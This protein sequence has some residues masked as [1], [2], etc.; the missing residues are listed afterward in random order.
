MGSSVA[1]GSFGWIVPFRRGDQEFA[2]IGV[3]GKTSSI[4]YLGKLIHDLYNV[5]CL[6]C[7]NVPLR[8]WIIPVAPLPRT[9]ADRVLA[10]G[11]A[12]GQTKPITGGGIFYGLLCAEAAARTVM[13]AFKRGDFSLGT[14][15]R[16]EEEWR[17][18]LGREIRIAAFFRRLAERLTDKDIDH[19]FRIVQS[20]G[21]L[22]WVTTKAH[23]DWHGEVIYF[24]LCHPYLG[25]IFLKGLFG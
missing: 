5:G 19:L 25:R 21:V 14:L 17:K 18:K 13:A 20:D 10:V 3:S 7:D 12:A 2:R 6:S 1:P 23:F 8:S 22:S 16:Y 15:S 24:A 4:P 9:F 11:D